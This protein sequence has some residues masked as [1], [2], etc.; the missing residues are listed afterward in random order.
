MAWIPII[1]TFILGAILGSFINVLIYRMPREES[2]WHPRSHCPHCKAMIP[3]FRNIPIISF[4][5][6]QGKCASCTQSIS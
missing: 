4:V 6:Q 5:I 1:A 2:L 3:W